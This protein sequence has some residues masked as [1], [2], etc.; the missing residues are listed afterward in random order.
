MPVQVR[1]QWGVGGQAAGEVKELFSTTGVGGGLGGGDSK[2]SSQGTPPPQPA[3]NLP[4]GEGPGEKYK[5]PR[6][7]PL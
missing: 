5:E 7:G 2:S 4:E 3:Y 1:A 6:R